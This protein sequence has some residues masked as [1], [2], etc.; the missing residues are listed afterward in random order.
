MFAK[1]G[2]NQYVSAHQFTSWFTLLTLSA[3]CSLKCG[4]IK[5]GVTWTT[6]EKGYDG[7][8]SKPVVWVV[9]IF[10]KETDCAVCLSCFSIFFFFITKSLWVGDPL[11]HLRRDLSSPSQ[12]VSRLSSWDCLHA[13]WELSSPLCHSHSVPVL[14]S[15]SMRLHGYHE[16]VCAWMYCWVSVNSHKWKVHE[17]KE[18]FKKINW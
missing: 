16:D 4:Q 11:S 10:S 18:K 8:A 1:P 17:K 5:H 14:I 13:L 15:D 7:G 3:G 12:S 9:Y 2:E 6:L